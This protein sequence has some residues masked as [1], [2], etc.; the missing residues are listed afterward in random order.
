MCSAEGIR[1]QADFKCGIRQDVV[2][3]SE[4]QTKDY[5]RKGPVVATVRSLG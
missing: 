5:N 4:R 1:T 3:D 2:R